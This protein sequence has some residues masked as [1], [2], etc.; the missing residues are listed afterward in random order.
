MAR[1]NPELWQRYL[2]E[3]GFSPELSALWA[4]L[5]RPNIQLVP[6]PIL[7]S[8]ATP[9]GV[10]KLGG[11]PDLP[12]GTRWPM[13][14][15]E[16]LTFLA[17]LDLAGLS[18]LG[19]GLRLP[20][21]G[22]LLFFYDAEA[23]P[24]GFDPADGSGTQVLYV[25][26]QVALERLHHPQRKATK[27]RT[28]E[29]VPGE[30]L[31]TWDPFQDKATEA[32]FTSERV[33]LEID[34]LSGEDFDFITYG[35]HVVGGWPAVIQNPM[36]LECQLASNGID[37]GGPEGYETPRARELAP[38]AVDWRLLL[39]LDCDDDLGWTWGD[40]GRLYFWCREQDMAQ[41][42][43]DRCWTVLQCF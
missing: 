26:G 41:R 40:A 31:P 29:L 42:R 28:V 22:R 1:T 8:D 6:G 19:T 7:G 23:Q 37:V 15:G 20:Q 35:A 12:I 3:R 33:A 5:V 17:Q 16:P 43:F 2:L 18:K 32:G 21:D 39:Q 9:T 11:N 10:T 36:E 24:W 27:V 38:G 30:C 34:K 14:S 25:D 13:R 4:S